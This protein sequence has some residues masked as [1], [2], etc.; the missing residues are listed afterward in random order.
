MGFRLRGPSIRRWPW[1][2]DLGRDAARLITG[3][4]SGQPILLMADRQ[5]TGGYANYCDGDL[6]RY[7]PGGATL[8]GDEIRFAVCT[9]ADALAALV[10]QERTLMAGRL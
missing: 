5:T 8:P 4:A 3:A 9:P 7:Q 1:G 6:R 2:N 10:A